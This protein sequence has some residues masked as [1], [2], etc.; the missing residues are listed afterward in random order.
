LP[1]YIDAPDVSSTA[2][3]MQYLHLLEAV[4]RRFLPKAKFDVPLRVAVSLYQ[5]DTNCAEALVYLRY[6]EKNVQ[7]PRKRYFTLWTEGYG[8]GGKQVC[9]HPSISL[10]AGTCLV[11]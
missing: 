11:L 1:Q 6:L 9:C 3:E 8:E 7:L 5:V 10:G 4:K 2:D